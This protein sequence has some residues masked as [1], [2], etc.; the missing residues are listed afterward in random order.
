MLRLLYLLSMCVLI[1]CIKTIQSITQMAGQKA[2]SAFLIGLDTVAFLLV[3]KDVITGELTVA[4]V[5]TMACG[6]IIGYYIGSYIEEKMALGKV[7]VTIKIAKE[8]QNFQ[9]LGFL[10]FIISRRKPVPTKIAITREIKPS[11]PR[12]FPT[13]NPNTSSSS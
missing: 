7:V 2:I 10:N 12:S 6:Y 4:V 5:T 1:R 9:R 3:F 11:I 13:T 8:Y